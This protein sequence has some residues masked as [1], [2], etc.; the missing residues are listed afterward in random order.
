MKR[1]SVSF[2][3]KCKPHLAAKQIAWLNGIDSEEMEGEGHDDILVH[4]HALKPSVFR[5]VISNRS[6]SF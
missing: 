1:T 3:L 4:S 5:I 2:N 6:S